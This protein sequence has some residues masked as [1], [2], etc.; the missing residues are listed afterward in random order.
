MPQTVVL[1]QSAPSAATWTDLYTAPAGRRARIIVRAGNRD[2]TTA[3][4][5]RA[6]ISNNGA[7]IADSQWVLIDNL[8]ALDCVKDTFIL[9]ASDV[10]RVYTVNATVTFSANG[11]EEDQPA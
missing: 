5:V 11:V 10:L 1:A 3:S 8:A 9:D 4:E 6:A 2:T 7:A